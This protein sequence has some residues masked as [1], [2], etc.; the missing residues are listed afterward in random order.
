MKLE[1]LL[2]PQ[3]EALPVY[4]P[5]RPI[6]VVA[7][8]L[9]LDP[10][11]VIKLASNEN[12]LGP[13]PAAIE[14]GTR[15]L[16]EVGLYPDNGGF[17]LV[18]ALAE[19]LAMPPEALMLA[20]GSNEVFYRLCDLFVRPGVEVVMG[21][22]A[23]VTYRI[24]TLLAG[25]EAV[26]VPMPGFTHDLEAMRAAITP[27]TRLVFLP[28][29]NNPTGTRVPAA[30]V[31]AFAASLPEHVVFCYDEAYAEY[32][33]APA[34]LR[35]LI[36]EGRKIVATRTF[37]KI[38]GL[39]GLRIGYGYG[40]RG[41]VARL[42]QVRPPFNTGNVAQACALAALR[43]EDWV[44]HSREVNTA[45]LHQLGA[46]LGALGLEFV[47]SHG[48]FVLVRVPE[49]STV[50]ADLQRRGI[51]VRPLAGYDLP[52]HLRIS[53]GTAPQNARCLEALSASLNALEQSRS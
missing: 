53:V 38:H 6:E 16:R 33:D 4:Q 11:T 9:G 35:P 43:D 36:A 22:Q 8:E 32:E 2:N 19:R 50:C 23:F 47:P 5:G 44:R 40:D 15:A 52:D 45:G 12:P 37:S 24:A 1:S 25:G 7:R 41:L 48:N 49:A 28:N 18:Q 46:G 51:I 17:A 10:R 14:A 21:T 31:L 29:P 3:I 27:R 13:S 42:N 30:A 20:A 39:A 26:R 34:D